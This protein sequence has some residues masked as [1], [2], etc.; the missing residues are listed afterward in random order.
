M[1]HTHF[2]ASRA[3]LTNVRFSDRYFVQVAPQLYYLRTDGRDGFY[4]NSGLTLADRRLPLS[5]SAMVNTALRTRIAAA[6]G[7]LWNVSLNYSIR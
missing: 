4:L 6:E 7:F 2:V 1:K 5:I 3:N